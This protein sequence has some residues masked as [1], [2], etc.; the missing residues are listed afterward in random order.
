M[1]S[2]DVKSVVPLLVFFLSIALVGRLAYLRPELH[3]TNLDAKKLVRE[4][5]NLMGTCVRRAS[6]S[7][8]T[9]AVNMRAA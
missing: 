7:Q 3:F 9:F 6:R 8:I 2:R 4:I 1:W 5:M